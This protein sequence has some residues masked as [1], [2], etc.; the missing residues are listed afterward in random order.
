MRW[1]GSGCSKPG[2]IVEDGVPRCH[3][4]GATSSA[5]VA[6]LVAE[7][8]IK[9]GGIHLPAGA[10]LGKAKLWWPPC[11][12]YRK[13]QEAITSNSTPSGDKEGPID[14]SNKDSEP[15]SVS[16]IY[17]RSLDSD[18]FR[19]IYLSDS[20]DVSSPIHI[21]L[22]EYPLNDHPEYET[23][24]YVWG[25][26]IGDSTP[27]RPVYVGRFWDVILATRN[28]S[29]LLHNL[30]RP[31][32]RRVI[33]VDAICINQTNNTEK[34][35]QISRMG[36]IYANCER[37]VA[38]LGEDLVSR[39]LGKSF[40]PRIDFGKLEL[41]DGTNPGHKGRSA[42]FLATC[43]ASA[44][45]SQDQLFQR[46]YLTRIWI[47]QELMLSK[48]AILPLGD[49]DILCDQ[50]E[51]T[52]LILRDNREQLKGSAVAGHSLLHLLR[53]TSH[54]HASDPRDKI[55][56]LLGLFKPQRISQKL[57]A[58]YS[59]SWRD[60]C[61]GSAAYV[62]LVE[63][64]IMLLAH[65]LGCNGPMNLPSWV[66]NIENATS[67]TVDIEI[68]NFTLTPA[69]NWPTKIVM[70]AWNDEK[71]QNDIQYMA[72]RLSQGHWSVHS[73]ALYT[74]SLASASIDSSDG[75][76]RIQALR[77]FDGPCRLTTET[78]EN[79]LTSIWVRGPSTA[80]Q[81]RTTGLKQPEALYESHWFY[82]IDCKDL[83]SYSAADEYRSRDANGGDSNAVLLALATVLPEK[84]SSVVT[85][86][87]CCIVFDIHIY[88]MDRLDTRIEPHSLKRKEQLHSLY[89][90]LEG[91]H[92]PVPMR[93]Y[94]VWSAYKRDWIF[95]CMFP[96]W[97]A[98]TQDIL[99][100]LVSLTETDIDG[101]LYVPPS[102]ADSICAAAESI[103][104]EF[105]PIIQDNYFHLTIK[106]K[107]MWRMWE[108]TSG[109]GSYANTLESRLRPSTLTLGV[110]YSY[111][112]VHGQAEWTTL[113]FPE[114]EHEW[115]EFWWGAKFPVT[116]RFSLH[117]LVEIMTSTMLHRLMRYAR[118]FSNLLNEDIQTLIG[119]SPVPEDR[120]VF[121]EDWGH[122]LSEELG[123]LW[124]LETITIV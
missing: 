27:C 113:C 82:I 65:A 72:Q 115:Y 101:Q 122:S 26:E 31:R 90:V 55:Y 18:H 79:G 32:V 99:P 63:G 54:C 111:P 103:C 49:L 80:A 12:P 37:V 24:S 35:A 96:S 116:V 56:G 19:L 50:K 104:P 61:L 83:D 121:F 36:D 4:C 53:A 46:R 74:T 73:R 14:P 87:A 8:Q 48:R 57:V 52:Q 15:S 45:M 42:Q 77:V 28:C 89:W 60:C 62:L 11:V 108:I 66:P 23:V 9:G 39:P 40:R 88:S 93:D 43:A 84:E 21:E 112:L 7:N 67:W 85:L 5:L 71:L 58:D 117:N 41:T 119:R 10:P 91:L 44:G 75:S 69:E 33:W 102:L 94:M 100:L 78:E 20:D 6:Q 118:G 114:Q 51:A 16:H 107:G 86:H 110:S 59:L 30:R 98:T 105:D 22:E 120:C 2:V 81:F 106:N 97:K 70:Y 47:V 34:P 3:S 95:P 124:K 109:A 92:P 123:L 76:L 1:H 29:A 38:Y 13:P 25:G 68:E 17:P 64:N